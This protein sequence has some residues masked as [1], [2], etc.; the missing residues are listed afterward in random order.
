MH[1]IDHTLR[2]ME[3]TK[4]KTIDKIQQ[5]NFQIE[6]DLRETMNPQEIYNKVKLNLTLQATLAPN[7]Q[8]VLGE[9]LRKSLP[10][11]LRFTTLN[12]SGDKFKDS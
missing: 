2:E 3:L 5:Q 11:N 12:N 8:K 7:M 1:R 9:R 6:R 10:R 4:K